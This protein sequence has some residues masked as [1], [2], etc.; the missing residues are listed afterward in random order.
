MKKAEAENSPGPAISGQG[1]KMKIQKKADQDNLKS[2]QAEF[3]A[4]IAQHEGAVNLY[5][6]VIKWCFF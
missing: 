6:Q 3:K 1:G 2:A 5:A 4:L